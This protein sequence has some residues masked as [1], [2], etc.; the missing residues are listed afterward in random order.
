MESGLQSSTSS[1]DPPVVK[2]IPVEL[3]RDLLNRGHGYLDVRTH[4]EF[5]AGHIHGAVNIP[6][7]Y[8]VET[9]MTKNHNFVPEVSS[10]FGKGDEIVVGCQ[11]G[12]RSQMA[13]MELW[14]AEFTG[15]TDMGGGYTAWVQSGFP[16]TV[17]TSN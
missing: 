7:M 14:A 4:E 11:S 12:R 3:A 1:V 6:Y 15:V 9:G 17:E 16:F 13:A 8:K 5:S 2:T 10:K